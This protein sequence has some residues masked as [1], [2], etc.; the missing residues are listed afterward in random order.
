MY[1]P[2]YLSM[3]PAAKSLMILKPSSRR[4]P[5]ASMTSTKSCLATQTSSPLHPCVLHFLMPYRILE[6]GFGHLPLP[7][8]GILTRRHRS[9]KPPPHATEQGD[10][11]DHFFSLQFRSHEPVLHGRDSWAVLHDMPP[12]MGC[13]RMLRVRPWTPPSQS[14]LHFE[15]EDH[16]DITQSTSHLNWLHFLATIMYPFFSESHVMPPNAGHAK[17]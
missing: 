6:L 4:E 15:N 7:R 14:L 3:R 10:H 2:M 16:L 17:P 9:V 11:F 5:L 8:I 13:V 1:L 12:F